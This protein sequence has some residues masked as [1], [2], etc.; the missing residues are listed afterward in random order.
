MIALALLYWLLGAVVLGSFMV[1]VASLIAA[2]CATEETERHRLGMMVMFILFV[3]LVP[4][5]LLFL[6]TTAPRL[7]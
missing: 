3:T 5:A 6:S 1:A 7:D 2:S 4:L